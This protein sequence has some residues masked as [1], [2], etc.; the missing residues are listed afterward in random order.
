MLNFGGSDAG[1]SAIETHRDA[2]NQTKAHYAAT[3][4]DVLLNTTIGGVLRTKAQEMPE[5]VA[6]VEVH[7]ADTIARRWT[8]RE[9]LD[10]S[11]ELAT[12]LVSRF[13]PG[14]RIAV[15]AP[16][17]PEWVILEFA[18]ALAGL[19]LVTV[20][21]AFRLAEASYTLKQ[22]GAVGL[23]FVDEFR[24]NRIGEHVADLLP[25][26]P[27]IR[28]T[29]RLTDLAAMTRGADRARPLPQVRP[30][31]PAFILYTS[32]TTGKPK[33]AILHHCGITNNARMTYIRLSPPAHARVVSAMPLFHIG[34][35]MVAVLG[36]VQA[37][38][39]LY[40]MRLF[41]PSA[42]TRLIERERIEVVSVVPTMVF[43]LVEQLAA[44]PRDVSCVSRILAGGAMVPP[45]LINRVTAI[46]GCGIQII[47]GQTECSGVLTETFVGDSVQDTSET[48]GKALPG[49]EISVR[50]PRTN[51]VANAGEVG[52]I[53][54]RGKGL[55]VGY[56]DNPDA[57]KQTFDDE[58]WLHTGDLG[59]MDERG[60]VR[61]T[62]RVKEMIIRGGENLYPAEIE[63]VILT[64]PDIA[65][66][67]VIGVP[68]LKWGETVACFV[69]TTTGRPIDQEA[70]KAFC[71]DRLSPQKTPIHWIQVQEWPMT[72]SGKI[73]K[74]ILK[75]RLEKE[76]PQK[77]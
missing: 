5:T 21:P 73:Q 72:A 38:G 7:P 43:G 45:E 31:D 1:M 51:V 15:W 53:C 48:V 70:L 60:Y 65:E 57:T 74:F 52:E 13:R 8:Y 3:T 66:A 56:N 17:I 19:T 20:N 44:E 9:L 22:S 55:M 6:L 25:S 47:Y 58:A 49:V 42:M 36:S 50:D 33:G 75:E 67:A 30:E 41:D 76:K 12:A 69:R 35:C 4:D 16:N 40:L 11:E 37:G 29:A 32:G 77:P 71:R 28:E 18:A 62:G 68:D 24:G 26:L 61:I 64:Y 23:F 63:N 54:A 46:F 34:G 39:T 2:M 14:E 27:L 59:A 10:Q